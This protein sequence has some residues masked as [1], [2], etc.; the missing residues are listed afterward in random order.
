MRFYEIVVEQLDLAAELLQEQ[1]PMQS[2][3]GLVLV[4]NAVEY[5]LYRYAADCFDENPVPSHF[6]VL[7]RRQR[8]KKRAQV[9]DKYIAP[10]IAYARSK[11]A[12]TED[13]AMFVRKAH[14][15][16]NQAYH[17]GRTHDPI[18][19]QLVSVYYAIFCQMIVGLSPRTIRFGLDQNLS[20]RVSRH[21]KMEPSAPMPNANAT[22]QSLMRALPLPPSTLQEAC[23]DSLSAQLADIRDIID[24]LV[25]GDPAVADIEALVQDVQFQH[26]FWGAAPVEGL[27][28]RVNDKGSAEVDPDQKDEW[29]AALRKMRST[30]SPSVS[31]KTLDRWETRI[32]QLTQESKPGIL[33][34]KYCKLQEEMEPFRKMILDRCSRFDQHVEEQIER[35][36]LGE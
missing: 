28:V 34:Q 11:D 25:R 1:H 36:F 17:A 19:T 4:D 29:E 15:F 26:A 22:A 32:D 20:P 18:I 8:H 2:R 31:A 21:L 5:A 27:T 9:L 14:G 23:R 7:E 35:R 16:R 33:L 13:Q 30:W 24:Y 12:I 3:L 10:K 6:P